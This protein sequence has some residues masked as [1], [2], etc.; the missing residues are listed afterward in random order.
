[1][2][3]NKLEHFLK[4]CLF[5]I[6]IL[7]GVEQ[8]LSGD[9]MDVEQGIRTGNKRQRTHTG[10]ALSAQGMDTESDI[11]Q[12]IKR[13]PTQTGGVNV[14]DIIWTVIGNFVSGCLPLEDLCSME[15]VCKTIAASIRD[16][17]QYQAIVFDSDNQ[18]GW[19][20]EEN[21]L[22]KD[23][24]LSLVQ[25]A[26]HNF[27]VH[28]SDLWRHW[29][30]LKTIGG[31]SDMPLHYYL[32][33]PLTIRQ[34]GNIN[35]IYQIIPNLCSSPFTSIIP[36]SPFF[37]NS[38]LGI[39]ITDTTKSRDYTLDRQTCMDIIKQTDAN[40]LLATKI[41]AQLFLIEMDFLGQ[42]GVVDYDAARR[43]FNLVLNVRVRANTS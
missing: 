28:F 14:F 10:E 43:G 6:T 38:L 37:Y 32:G 2:Y 1:M 18:V 42:G 7:C 15:S 19:K 41:E 9:M 25:S 33:K 31:F 3:T 4:L 21:I 23:L 35:K 17:R 12:G 16:A 30:P 22:A 11:L 26:H 40:C 8:A 36:K 24:F 13:Q 20:T 39:M 34:R 5:L 29:F 27:L